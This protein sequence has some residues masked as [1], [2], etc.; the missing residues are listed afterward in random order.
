EPRRAILVGETEAVAHL[1]HVSGRMKVVAVGDVPMQAIAE[2]LRD[3]R[4]A[5]T[6]Y[7][8]DDDDRNVVRNNAIAR[9]THERHIAAMLRFTEVMDREAANRGSPCPSA[10]SPP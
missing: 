4:L 5:G 7:T 10:P 2:A 8:H 3:R 9:L 1:P 6:R